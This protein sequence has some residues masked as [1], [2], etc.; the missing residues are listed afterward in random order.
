MNK[1]DKIPYSEQREGFSF[2]IDEISIMEFF[3]YTIHSI[4]AYNINETR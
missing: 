4:Q 3:A 1:A 2:M